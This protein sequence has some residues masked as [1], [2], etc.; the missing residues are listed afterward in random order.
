MS[1]KFAKQKDRYRGRR[2]VDDMG[3]GEIF[4][5]SQ[6]RYEQLKIILFC[7]PIVLFVAACVFY[8]KDHCGPYEEEDDDYKHS[9]KLSSS[10]Y[11]STNSL[12]RSSN[13]TSSRRS[14]KSKSRRKN[15]PG[16]RTCK[17]KLLFGRGSVA[18][19][20]LKRTSNPSFDLIDDEQL[21][22]IVSRSSPLKDGNDNSTNKVGRFDFSK[23]ERNFENQMHGCESSIR[24][25][26]EQGL[27]TFR[28]ESLTIPS[29]Q[30]DDGS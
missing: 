6:H 5:V 27:S 1:K 19:E 18:S 11:G 28:A 13:S 17:Q 16:V 9:S 30:Y 22:N 2:K 25:E 3:I 29:Y 21:R 12:V 4:E 8:V 7:V 24:Q 10:T 23:M 14:R 15:S 26:M 20:F